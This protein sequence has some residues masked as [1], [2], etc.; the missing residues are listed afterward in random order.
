MK[1][2]FW[3]SILLLSQAASAQPSNTRTALI[4]GVAQY[5]YP[6]LSAL[7]GVNID[8]VS[9][10]KIANAMGIPDR[11]IKYLKN[12]DAT[13]ENVLKA[14]NDLSNSTTEGSRS[15]VYFSGH[16]TRQQVGENCVKNFISLQ[17]I[18]SLMMN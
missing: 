5:G 7:D 13:K 1:Y 15:F 4:I 14:L 6:G 3:L 11:N 16:G 8:M 9:T 10:A 12:S 17:V 18:F 2:V